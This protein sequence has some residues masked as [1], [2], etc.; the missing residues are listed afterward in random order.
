RRRWAGRRQRWAGRRRLWAFGWHVPPIV[1]RQPGGGQSGHPGDPPRSAAKRSIPACT[2]SPVVV[3]PSALGESV[4]LSI[5][6][7]AYNERDYLAGAV[8]TVVAGLHARGRSFELLVSEN[9][10]SD[11]TAAEAQRLRCAHPEI[12]VLSSPVADYG[13]AL[14]EGFSAARGAYVVNFDVD[15]VDLEFLDPAVAMLEAGEAAIVVGSKRGAGAADQRSWGRKL[16]TAVYTALLQRGFGLGVSDT[17]GLKALHRAEV[18]GIV[19]ACRFG[20]DIFDSELVIRAERA[21]LAV[22]E[23]P[24]SVADQRPPR[25]SIISRIPRSLVG[26][27]RLRIALWTEARQRS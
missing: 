6:M 24:V 16:V 3:G 12:R 17:H 9:G 18:A 5:V 1:A 2:V 19:A 15:F 8:E 25:S 21:G 4:Q 7:P 27:G 13:R 11:G 26:L 20:A 14:R 10:S 23:L 22:R